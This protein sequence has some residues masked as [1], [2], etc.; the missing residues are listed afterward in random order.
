MKGKRRILVLTSILSLAVSVPAFAG[1]THS[2][3]VG[4]EMTPCG[5]NPAIDTTQEVLDVAYNLVYAGYTPQIVAYKEDGSTKINNTT[6]TTDWLNS[7][8]VYL[9][10]HGWPSGKEV[11]WTNTNTNL[12]Y[13]VC[14]YASENFGCNIEDANLSNCKLAIMAACYSGLSNGIAQSFQKNGAACAIGW[15]PSVSSV[16]MARYNKIL[17]NYLANGTT[18]QN[19]IKG[20]NADIVDEEDINYDPNVLKYQTYGSGVYNTIKK[21]FNRSI[22]EKNITNEVNIFDSVDKNAE[23][24]YNPDTF[25]NLLETYNPV[26][27]SIEYR[28]GN[29]AEIVSYIQE[30]MDSRFDKKLFAVN[31]VETIPGDDSDMIITYRYKI[32]DVLSDFGY[33]V[34][35]ENYKMVGIKEVGQDLYEYNEPVMFNTRDIKAEKIQEY[36]AVAEDTG[37]EVV[38]QSLDIRFSSKDKKYVYNVNTDYKTKDGGIYR[39][40]V[41]R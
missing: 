9:A 28:N 38:E 21:N 16:S 17:T 36:N 40:R 39:V 18:I 25:I 19:A 29:D 14:N 30:N 2:Y 35:I 1:A 26:D 7:G 32:G 23:G 6:V 27:N 8:V 5:T 11:L 33:N 22:D 37:D 20:A 34:N 31:Q 4:A 15:K 10:G 13:R 24:I 41:S 3:S 12:E